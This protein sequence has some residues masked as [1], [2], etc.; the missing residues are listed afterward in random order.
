RRA[1]YSFTR[2]SVLEGYRD[3]GTTPKGDKDAEAL[4]RPPSGKLP[5]GALSSFSSGDEKRAVGQAHEKQ[6]LITDKMCFW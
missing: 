5:E 3:V 6:K 2:A 1:V 4:D